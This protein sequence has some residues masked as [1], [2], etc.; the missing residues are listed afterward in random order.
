MPRKTLRRQYQKQ[1][2]RMEGDKNSSSRWEVQVSVQ[3]MESSLVWQRTKALS[4]PTRRHQTI[5]KNTV[6]ADA[7]IE[8]KQQRNYNHVFWLLS[9]NRRRMHPEAWHGFG[10]ICTGSYANTTKYQRKIYNI[11]I[12]RGKSFRRQLSNYMQICSDTQTCTSRLIE[13][14]L[15]SMTARKT[16]SFLIDISVP[17]NDNN[18]PEDGKI[19]QI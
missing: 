7:K 15:L 9:L 12:Y 18:P 14:I 1:L 17:T 8:K 19:I 4:I 6:T 13:Q 16:K 11:S 2:S 3:R 5:K 10:F